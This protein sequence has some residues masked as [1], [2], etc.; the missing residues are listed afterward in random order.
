MAP[1]LVAVV[2]TSQVAVWSMILSLLGFFSCGLASLPGFIMG[3]V[4][5][6]QVNRTGHQGRGMAIAGIVMGAIGLAG[7]LILFLAGVLPI[8]A[9]PAVLQE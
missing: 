1:L 7:W 9:A 2:P 4:G 3:L 8:L 5:L 6:S